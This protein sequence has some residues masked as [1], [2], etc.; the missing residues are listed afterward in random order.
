MPERRFPVQPVGV[1]YLC[2]E[3]K[4]G[5][6]IVTPRAITVV[7]QDGIPHKCQNCGKEYLFNK[8]YPIVEWLFPKLDA[9]N[10]EKAN[11]SD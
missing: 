7:G 10:E 11:E 3:C 8:K 9:V 5:L 4:K 6:A 1:A 2:D